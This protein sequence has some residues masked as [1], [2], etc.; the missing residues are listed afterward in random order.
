MADFLVL[1]TLIVLM[2]LSILGHEVGHYLAYKQYDANP[3]FGYCL[4]KNKWYLF[5][6]FI[7]PIAGNAFYFDFYMQDEKNAW[8]KQIILS[9]AGLG[10]SLILSELIF[11]PILPVRAAGFF[12]LATFF[13]NFKNDSS[14][15]WKICKALKHKENYVK[16]L[17]ET[18]YSFDS[19]DEY[20]QKA[21]KK[22][23]EKYNYQ[24]V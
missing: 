14:D 11:V 17:I 8:K 3:K 21:V 9:G 22:I 16:F 23:Q 7:T 10:V 2:I 13:S 12:N 19:N 24:N 4:L 15:G 1:V 5:A 20:L 6:P 18:N